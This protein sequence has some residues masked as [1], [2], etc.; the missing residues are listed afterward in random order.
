MHAKQF[1]HRD[2]K[3]E[4]IL[5]ATKDENSELKLVDFGL[6]NK[7]SSGELHT[8][9]GTPIY[10]S[11]EMLKG[12]YDE[13]CDNWSIGVLM[14]ILLCGYPPFFGPNKKVIYELIKAGK[15]DFNGKEWNIISNEAKDLIRNLLVV[16]PKKRLS[17]K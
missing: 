13:K 16:D 3:L 15:F 2:L 5:Y 4:N 12:S 14:Y 10:I 7:L 1:V 8:M 9:I 6:S 11:P 17:A